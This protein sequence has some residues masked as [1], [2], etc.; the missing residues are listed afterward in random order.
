MILKN[1]GRALRAAAWKAA[2][3]FLITGI[4]AGAFEIGAAAKHGAEAHGANRTANHAPQQ[5]KPFDPASDVR[6]EGWEPIAD[7]EVYEKTGLFGYID[8]G[9]EIFL[10]YGFEAAVV[11]RFTREEIG[12]E[13]AVEIC[14]ME[15]PVDAFGIYSVKREGDERISELIEAENWVGPAQASFVKGPYYVSLLGSRVAEVDLEI[16]AAEVARSVPGDWADAPALLPAFEA[17]P[18]AEQIGA[19]RRYIKG[20]LAAVNESPIFEDAVWDFAGGRTRAYSAK[21][22][23]SNSKTVLVD[24]GAAREDITARVEAL[25]REYLEG[26]LRD[27]PV[28]RAR[29]AAGKHFLFRQAGRWAVLVLG[30]PDPAAARARL[31]E[32][33]NEFR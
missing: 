3:A 21:Y 26:V 9:A 7:P 24:F 32:T 16:A 1:G 27:G 20:N 10:Q 15:S 30:E 13:I 14:R 23:P 25:F 12:P 31:D 29:N 19:S 11:L 4:A 28:V 8:G 2:L 18:A 5:T 33:L 22:A 17:L 6:L